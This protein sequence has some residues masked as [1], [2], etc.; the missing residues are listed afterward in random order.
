MY[1]IALEKKQTVQYTTGK[2][3]NL[4]EEQDK[5]KM[6]YFWFALEKNL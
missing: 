5:L 1:F 6:T 2:Y 4:I 3:R